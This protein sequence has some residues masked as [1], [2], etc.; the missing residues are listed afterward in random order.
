MSIISKT[1][2]IIG[3]G[4]MGSSIACALVEKGGVLP[5]EISLYDT[6]IAK[7]DV[8]AEKIGCQKKDLT[9][10]VKSSGILV[11]AVKPQDFD[12]LAGKISRNIK[13]SH[14][15]VS[16]MAGIKT[17]TIA[18]KI[19]KNIAVARAMPNMAAVVRESMTGI[20][21]NAKVR[22]RDEVRA[23]FTCMGKVI[24]IEERFMDAVTALSGSA[25]A[26]LFYLAYSMMEA[27]ESF[28]LDEKNV[29]ELVVQTLYG[30]ALLMRDSG[31]MPKDL[32][33]KVASKGG[34]TESALL[35]LEERK[36]K[37]AIKEAVAKAKKKAGEL[38]Q[39]G[40][41]K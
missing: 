12:N 23:I 34:T 31:S 21:Y 22:N 33:K 41:L 39:E 3:C 15:L 38:S 17:R 20:S 9:D 19:G 18:E 5:Q 11:I 30:A 10:L 32:I 35:V 2:G 16:I 8:L 37:D 27:G 4:N 13:D 25:P 28:G 29:K 24:E 1:I 7:K 6:V 36:V 26:Y 40:D 14:I